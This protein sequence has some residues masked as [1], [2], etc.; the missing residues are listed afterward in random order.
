ME[1]SVTRLK[2]VL[3]NR[4]VVEERDNG[5]YMP[6]AVM[7]LVYEKDSQFCVLLNQR[8]Q[9]VEHHKGEMSFPGGA[10]D[11]D[12]GVFINTALRETE[13]EMGIKVQDITVLGQLDDTITRSN[14]VVKVFVGTI[15]Y[16]YDFN[17]S[18]IEI[19]EVV[20]IPIGEL[21]SPENQYTETRWD[22]VSSVDATSYGYGKYL[23]YGATAT[24]LSQF[25]EVVSSNF[26]M[27]AH[28]N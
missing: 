23:I 5:E 7:V 11:P 3:S 27:E 6:A 10:K 21:L 22:G 25:L 8:S 17:P 13:E 24:I 28:V 1:F 2:D 12:D 16:P 4:P 20:E 18:D 15:D 19:A 26:N 9:L 14:F